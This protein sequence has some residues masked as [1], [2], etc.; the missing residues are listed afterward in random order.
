M[1]DVVES[2]V[3]ESQPQEQVA[4]E[5]VSDTLLTGEESAVPPQSEG[6]SLLTS[7]DEGEAEPAQA[8]S[9]PE[10]YEITPSEGFEVTPEIMEVVSPLFKKYNISQDGAQELAN[11]HMDIMKQ[12]SAAAEKFRTEMIQG[13]VQ[14]IKSDPE[15][16]GAKFNENMAMARRGLRAVSPQGEGKSAL[17]DLLKASGMGNHPEIIKAFARVG[18]M[19]KEDSILDKGT[20]A[21]AKNGKTI[22][23]AF[24]KSLSALEPKE[25]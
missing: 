22:A 18:R 2:I 16:G 7:E 14:E 13:W 25:D 15:F 12:Q 4:V 24:A 17:E 23:D 19:V 9:I 11:A 5:P 8:P 3:T 21:S 20:V 6:E 1:A 10:S